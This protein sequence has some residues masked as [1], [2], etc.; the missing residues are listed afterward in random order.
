MPVEA[1]GIS[2]RPVAPARAVLLWAR[3]RRPLMK[4]ALIVPSRKPRNPLVAHARFRQAGRHQTAA[5]GARQQAKR[6]L[7]QELDRLRHPSP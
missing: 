3:D 5:H 6:A 7:R 4:T 1:A 2:E